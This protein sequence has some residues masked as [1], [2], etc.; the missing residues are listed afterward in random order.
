ML[1]LGLQG[2]HTEVLSLPLFHWCV[3]DTGVSS[4]ALILT[5]KWIVVSFA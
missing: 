2:S 5:M 1:G 3:K 4:A